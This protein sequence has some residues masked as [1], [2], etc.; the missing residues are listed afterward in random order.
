MVLDLTK[1]KKQTNN[2]YKN[3]I[4]H[5]LFS[6]RFCLFC[7]LKVYLKKKVFFYFKLIFF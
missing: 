1:K 2:E 7:I 6:I 4:S 3:F 5:D